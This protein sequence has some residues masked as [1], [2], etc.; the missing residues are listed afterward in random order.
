MVGISKRFGML[1]VSLVAAVAFSGAASAA[2]M[3]YNQAFAKCKAEIAGN[4]PM[5]DSNTSAARYTAGSACMKKYG[6]RLK[7]GAM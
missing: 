5:T 4:V 3:T 6:Y 7:K 2:K 1:A